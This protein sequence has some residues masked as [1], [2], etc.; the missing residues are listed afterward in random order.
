MEM[1]KNQRDHRQDFR[2]SVKGKRIPNRGKER[3]WGLSFGRLNRDLSQD[4]TVGGVLLWINLR[5]VGK[6]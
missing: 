6:V 2:K 5:R 4:F 3:Q 1:T